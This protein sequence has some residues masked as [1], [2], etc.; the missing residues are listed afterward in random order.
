M[1]ELGVFSSWWPSC[2]CPSYRCCLESVA[3]VS[4]PSSVEEASTDR[5]VLIAGLYSFIRV[6]L[7]QR[8]LCRATSLLFCA[9]AARLRSP[10]WGVLHLTEPGGAGEKVKAMPCRLVC[11]P[12]RQDSHS[13]LD[14]PLG[15]SAPSTPGSVLDP[16]MQPLSSLVAW[17]PSTLALT[18][19]GSGLSPRAAGRL[20]TCQAESEQEAPGCSRGQDMSQML[21][22]HLNGSQATLWLCEP[23]QTQ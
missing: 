21:G 4:P 12:S 20:F 19:S 2:F 3:T 6:A 15:W 16:L 22:V 5:P 10:P 1:R 23:G 9:H 7:R 17:A 13:S 11:R 18:L 14:H 8:L